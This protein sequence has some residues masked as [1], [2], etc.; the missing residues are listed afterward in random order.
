MEGADLYGDSLGAEEM[1][2]KRRVRKG[3]LTRS[4]EGGGRWTV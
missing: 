1:T 4:R 3:G 2:E